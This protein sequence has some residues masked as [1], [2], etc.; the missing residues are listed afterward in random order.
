MDSVHKLYMAVLIP[1]P[2]ERVY[3]KGQVSAAVQVAVTSLWS[4]DGNQNF[5]SP[6]LPVKYLESALLLP[7]MAECS[8]NSVLSVSDWRAA[9]SACTDLPP[10]CSPAAA[11]SPLSVRCLAGRWHALPRKG[12]NILRDCS[13]RQSQ[14]KAGGW[15]PVFKLTGRWRKGVT[16]AQPSLRSWMWLCVQSLIKHKESKIWVPVCHQVLRTVKIVL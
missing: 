11:V 16:P 14:G 5:Q 10:R 8:G 2:K 3:P 12:Q 1:V 7:L 4:L 15:E 13:P 9:R 6:G